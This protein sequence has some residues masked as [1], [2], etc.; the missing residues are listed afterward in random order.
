MQDNT[1]A[2]MLRK[3]IGE[4][5]G[6]S[7]RMAIIEALHRTN[8]FATLREGSTGLTSG[9]L[10]A[11]LNIDAGLL[12][13]VLNYLAFSDQV[14]E[15][16]G[17]RF[18]LTAI[19]RQWLF[20][21]A[22]IGTLDGYRA[23]ACLQENLLAALRGEKRY[24]RDFVR[25]GESLA[26]ASHVFSRAT[27]G[28][29]VAEMARLQISS[30]VDLG[31]GAAQLLNS[32]LSM[33]PGLQGIGIDIDTGCL[34]EASKAVA[35]AGYDERVSLHEG[36]L[37]Q[38]ETFVSKI[39]TRPVAM[40]AI[41]VVHEL[42]RD[43]EEAFIALLRRYKELFAGSYFFIGEFDRPSD[44]E[45]R[46]G[47]ADA[48]VALHYQ[49]FIH[50]LSLQGLPRPRAEWLRLFEAAG[51]EVIKTSPHLGPRLVVYVLRL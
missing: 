16:Q 13:G 30:V 2:A 18:R 50:P 12:D 21:D 51:I 31:C 38:P 46:R 36:D 5:R 3:W 20:T 37:S 8:V 23:Y 27:H 11:R 43:G 39:A 22:V 33:A 19:G 4:L 25:D 10:G 48:G 1:P 6:G 14:L 42:L 9:E 41:A 28:W 40:T 24:G 45:F 35:R 15:K 49:H 26:R 7:T 29:I 17:D 34:R 47:I 32:L 44:D